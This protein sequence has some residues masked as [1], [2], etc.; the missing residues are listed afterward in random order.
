MRFELIHFIS[1]SGQIWM[2]IFVTMLLVY[3]LW[4]YR[5]DSLLVFLVMLFFPRVFIF[6]GKN[7]ENLYKVSLLLMCL[8]TCWERKVWLR[9]TAKDLL[10]VLVFI[11]LSASFFYSTVLYSRD[12]WTIIFSQYA[13]YLEIFLLWFLLKDA[14]FYRNEKD[15][16]LQFLYEVVILQIIISIFKLVIFRHQVEGL[17]GSFTISGGGIGTSFPVIGFYIIYIY[18]KGVFK[19][20]DWWLIV[21]LFLLG[22]TTGKRAVWII[23]PIIIMLFFSYVRGARLNKYMILGLLA[24]PIM[25]YFG[26]RLTPTLNPEHQ[27][28]G[29]FDLQHLYDYANKYQF[30]E[31]GIE[32]QR[33]NIQGPKQVTYD[34]GAY[35]L[36]NEQIEAAGRGNATIEL[37]K[38]IFGPRSLTEQDIWGTGL[39]SFYSTTYEEFDKLPL[40]IHLS[41]KGAGTGFFQ[42]YATLGVVGAM[43]MIIFSLIPYFRIKHRRIKWVMMVFFLYDYFMYNATTCR[44]TNLVAMIFI[45]IFSVNYEY[46]RAKSERLKVRG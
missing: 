38:L 9:Y 37:F 17:V 1:L 43:L 14:I 19:K 20:L 12:S 33:E 4:K 16:I 44:D 8:Y 36:Q 25:I 21:G 42:M 27:V 3:V 28:W 22:W 13:R 35:G 39:S 41:Y 18:R 45:C 6:M 34:G 5:R 23:L 26:A 15:K 29:S 46:L 7:V 32:G 30:G 10:Y 11:I 40:T 2:Q 24:F 31:E